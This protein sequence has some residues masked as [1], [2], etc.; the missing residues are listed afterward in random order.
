V[1]RKYASDGEFDLLGYRVAV[2][3][4][5]P[6]DIAEDVLAIANLEDPGRRPASWPAERYLERRL[7]AHVPIDSGGGPMEFVD[8]AS[9]ARGDSLLGVLVA[10]ADSL[11]VAIDASLE[12]QE[13]LAGL[14]RLSRSLDEFFAGSLKTEVDRKDGKWRM[15][16]T[17]F[18]GGDDLVMVGPWDVMFDLA[19]QIHCWFKDRFG[20]QG[21]TISSGLAIIKPKR[22]IRTA[23]AEAERLLEAA[24]TVPSPEEESPKNQCAAFGQI[25][26]WE[27]HET[28]VETALKLVG[29]LDAGQIERG[30]LHT[31][32]GLVEARHPDTVSILPAQ[33]TPDPLA[34]ARLAHHVSRNY[35]RGSEARRWAEGLVRRFDDSSWPDVRFLPAA[36]RYALTAT[37]S[38]SDRE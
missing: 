5:P 35:R 36:L 10:D 20:D 21:L 26:K 24:K 14:T 6:G 30:W 7:M 1:I 22:P 23:V 38:P 13:D 8:I 17:V 16:Y 15:V 29:W 18:A 19:G 34:T 2:Q 32:L 37:R 31:L 28:I 3:H 25:W 27:H 12:G 9:T 33:R 4:D 11:G